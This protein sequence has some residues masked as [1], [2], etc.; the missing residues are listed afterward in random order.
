[1]LFSRLAIL[2]L[3]GSSH[4]QC[5]YS[6]DLDM[7]GIFILF[8]VTVWAAIGFALWKRLVRPR[9]QSSGKLIVVTLALAAIWF[10]GPVLDEILGDRSFARACAE[11]PE[12]KFH[13]PLAIG[14]GAFFDERGTPHWNNEDEF[15]AI[16]RNSKA[17]YELFD[18]REEV[19]R[20]RSW[21]I[22]IFQSHAIYFAK[23]SGNPIVESYFRISPG[24]WVR[25]A[26]A[27]GEYG[28]YQCPRKGRFPSD[29]EF[30]VFKPR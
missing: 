4:D 26:I 28:P 16:K 10:V 3:F 12:V 13:G 14:P 18:V 11:M 25:R 9:I 5:A 7:S 29:P 1:M 24:G 21:P 15:F 23:A 17:W 20:V 27:L 2:C 22:P 8:A 19:I 6:K 30:L